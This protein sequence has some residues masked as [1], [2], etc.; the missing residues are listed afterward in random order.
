MGVRVLLGLET[1]VRGEIISCKMRN[2]ALTGHKRA[3]H[4]PDPVRLV[5]LL[6]SASSST[7]I[8]GQNAFS[9]FL[10]SSGLK[11]AI[12]FCLWTRGDEIYTMNR[13]DL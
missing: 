8:N 6:D 2:W 4:I 5:G 9:S 11:I 7:K 13:A 12:H 1:G 3:A 10:D